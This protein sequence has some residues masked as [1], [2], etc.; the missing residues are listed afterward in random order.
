[1]S[2]AQHWIARKGQ[3]LQGSLTIPGDKSVS[4]RSVM[5]AA[6]ADGTSHIEGFLEGEDTRATAR[7]FSQLGVRIE[8]PSPSQR[9]VHGVGID[10]LKAPEAPLDCGNAGTG[11]RLLAG[12][13]AGQA[14]DCTLIGDES[15]SGRPMRRVTGPLSQ[16]GARIDTQDDGTPPLHV[17]GGQT[18]HGIDFASPVASAQIKSAVL[19]AGLYA[20]GETRVVEPH[21]TRDYTERM[22]SAFGVDIEFSPGKARLRGG[23]RLRATDIVV[24]ADFS[25]AAFYLVAASIIPGSELRL[26]Q[27]GL[28]PRRTGLLHA[29]RLMGADI[30][31]E[32][33][34][35]QGG[36]P[37]ADL[38]V[39]YAPLKGARIPEALV[40]DMIDEFPALFVAAAAAEGQ[41]VV[42]G[43][44]EL[45][46]KE[47][48]RLAAMATGLRALGMQVDE[49]E[50]GATLHGGARL[51]SGT[52][53]SH[54]DHR[55]AM[56]F[57]I[58]GQI[59]DGEVRINDIANV[60]TSFPDFDGLARS[61]GFN[62][63]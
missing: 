30:T 17:H 46:V 51:G 23:Q 44:A 57:A 21:P 40:P 7:I 34:A 25:S 41:T 58:A 19:L 56:A 9:I 12:L 52:I 14:F 5:F 20:Q 43:A 4:H 50:D 29:L 2:N 3:P 1:M 32:N 48:D 16:M 59:S 62:L 37:V 60:A 33:P 27:V 31:E 13:L 8:T 42:S 26:K 36:E 54:G 6:L 28:N 11:M 22:L 15:L 49:T 35:E 47:S 55:I 45:R 38:V 18:L 10:G 63:A 39:R 53:E 61:A 24:P